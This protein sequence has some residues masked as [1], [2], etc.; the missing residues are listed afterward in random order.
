MHV[1]ESAAEVAFLRDGDGPVRRLPA[2]ARHRG[3]A[4]RPLAVHLL[5]E[6]GVADVRA[7]VLIH[8]RALRR[9]PTSQLAA[10][11]DCPVAHC[12]ASTRSSATAS[13]PAAARLLDAG[14][15]VGLGPDSVASNYGLGRARTRRGRRCSSARVRPRRRALGPTRRSR[16]HPRG[17]ARRLADASVAGGRARPPTWRLRLDGRRRARLAAAPG[18]RARLRLAGAGRLTWVQGRAAGARPLVRGGRVLHP[19]AD[20]VRARGRA[21]AARLA[22]WRGTLAGGGP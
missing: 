15:R 18:G 5:A 1:S 19:G 2:R 16:G 3:G 6:L 12:P 13:R 17:A 20:A 21:A 14:V 9:S 22:A 11:Y 7:P 4:A 10:H 8:R